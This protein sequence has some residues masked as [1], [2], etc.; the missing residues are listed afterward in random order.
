MKVMRRQRLD[1]MI[2][3]LGDPSIWNTGGPSEDLPLLVLLV[4]E[5]QS[6]V[7]QNLMVGKAVLGY[8]QRIESALATLVSK[9]RSVVVWVIPM[10]QKPTSDSTPT[11]IGANA[12]SAI[13][14]SVKTPDAEKAIMGTS[15]GPDDPTATAL[16]P[17]LGYAVVAETGG[18]EVVRFGYLRTETASALAH[19]R[20]GL[21][22]EVAGPVEREPDPDPAEQASPRASSSSEDAS[23][24][25][26]PARKRSPRRSRRAKAA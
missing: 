21:R 22:R 1:Q 4:D 26:R 7:D 15:P 16:P 25:V 2:E 3:L 19:A 24:R 14:F 5:V 20:A 17:E 6:F 18:R 10:T 13:A 9:G 12:A 23:E 11:T 8:R